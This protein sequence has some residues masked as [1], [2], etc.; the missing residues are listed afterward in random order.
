MNEATRISAARELFGQLYDA[1]FDSPEDGLECLCEACS[2]SCECDDNCLDCL[3]AAR[4]ITLEAAASRDGDD[5]PMECGCEACVE[6]RGNAVW[7]CEGEACL[8]CSVREGCCA[9]V[10]EA[11]SA[12]Q[13]V[14]IM[15]CPEYSYVVIHVD[16]DAGCVTFIM[17][18]SS[19]QNMGGVTASKAYALWAF[20]YT[21]PRNES[22]NLEYKLGFFTASKTVRDCRKGEK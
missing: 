21:L 1:M 7:L 4:E 10:C 15:P 14:H 2:G 11:K 20:S 18:L 9:G 17:S 19:Y 16:S 3:D 13:F 12:L 22:Y 6:S 8:V 5:V